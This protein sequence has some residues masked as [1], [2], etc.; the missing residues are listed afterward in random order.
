MVPRISVPFGSNRMGTSSSER[1]RRSRDVR[2]ESGAALSTIRLHNP[3][4]DP[5]GC[6]YCDQAADTG[7]SATPPR[8]VEIPSR[9]AA[10]RGRVAD[11]RP[12]S[13][14]NSRNLVVW[15]WKRPSSKCRKGPRS[16]DFSW[17]RGQDLN[18][19]P[20]GYEPDDLQGQG[21][22]PGFQATRAAS[23]I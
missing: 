21:C 17:W 8:G 3:K 13:R 20:S 22:V 4:I 12:H 5:Q 16:K 11:P 10:Y 23:V 14:K 9:V 15:A 6:R 7:S 2:R 1:G 18:L 19:R